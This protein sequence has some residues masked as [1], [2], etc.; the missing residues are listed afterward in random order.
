MDQQAKS[1]ADLVVEELRTRILDMP[2]PEYQR[3]LRC[4]ATELRERLPGTG[5]DA[6]EITTLL[7]GLDDSTVIAAVR[8][9]GGHDLNTL[10]EAYGQIDDTRPTVIIA[11]TIKGYGLPTEGHPQNHSSLLSVE[12]Y[13]DLAGSLGK[14]T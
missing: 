6:G 4:T 7:D 10:R 8:N 11:Y 2:N 5:P 3:L 13:A 14:D 1:L 9:L 12:Q